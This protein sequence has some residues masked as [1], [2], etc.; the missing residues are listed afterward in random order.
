ME[1]ELS[2][3]ARLDGSRM[4]ALERATEKSRRSSAE[5]DTANLV[6]FEMRQSATVAP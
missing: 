6:P 3:S 2:F 4:A 1:A 5:L